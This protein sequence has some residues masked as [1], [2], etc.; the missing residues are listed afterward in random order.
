MSTSTHL[1]L[2]VYCGTARP[3]D[4][5]RCPHCGRPWIDVRVG[6]QV[7]DR[8]PVMAGVAAVAGEATAETPT[9]SP[10]TSTPPESQSASE[11]G[12]FPPIDEVADDDGSGNFRW[13]IPALIA[14]I[15]TVVIALFAFGVLDETAETNAAPATTLPPAPTTIGPTTVPPTP[16]TTI[17][18]TTT[19][20]TTSTTTTT[21]PGPSTVEAVGAAVPFSALT[22]TANGI[23]PIAFGDAAPDA[24]GRLIASLGEPEETGVA[25]DEMGL[26]ADD[27]GRFM[28]WAGLTIAVTGTFADGTFSGYRYENEA[29]PTMHL[30]LATPSGLRIG[31]PIS[32]LNQIYSSY[33]IDYLSSGG[34]DLFRLSDTDGPLLWGPVS[35]IEDSGRVEGLYAP[36]ACS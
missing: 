16:T 18:P 25:G 1:P 31:D 7:E 21:I 12:G 5:T 26:C 20:T 22:L 33:Q 4:Q 15:A 10:P 29:V 2:C 8:I 9:V 17:A 27:D 6:A 13:L 28:R 3:A 30:D 11:D 32:T 36:T 23:G 14:A 35:S 24:I 34:V 19:S